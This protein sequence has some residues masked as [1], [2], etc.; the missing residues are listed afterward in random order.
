MLKVPQQDLTLRIRR[1]QDL[2]RSMDVDALVASTPTALLYLY[3]GVYSGVAY[4]PREGEAQYF[5]R[6]PSSS[7]SADDRLNYIRKI[8]QITTHIETNNIRKVALELDE[9]PYNDIVRQQ[10]IFPN[11]SLANATAILRAV[12]M[13]KTPYEIEQI[14][15]G[16]QKHMEVYRR[17]KDVYRSG[18][19]DLE[20]QIEIEHL[21][22]EG[23]STGLFRC[24]GAMMEFH[25]GSLLAGENAQI[26]SPYDFALGGAGSTALPLGANGTKLTHG[27]S[28][29]VDMAGNYGVYLSDIT[30][31]YAIGTLPDE[32]YKLHELSRRIHREVIQ[33]AKA[34]SLCSELYEKSLNIVKQEQAQSYFMGFG[35]QAQFVGHGLGL[36]INELPVL[37]A[38][39]KDRLEAGMVVAFEP[40]FVLPNVGALGVEN[41]YLIGENTVE[42]LTPLEEEIIT[43]EP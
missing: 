11:A 24:F 4:I 22:R 25:M 36:Q 35:H 6:R 13:V 41:T 7:L 19:T 15:Q 26:P 21:M 8:E 5:V 31:T 37:T 33:G 27:I 40:K 29:M 20:F 10:S 28:I 34:G 39:S 17:I 30:R 23:G 14:R 1:L 2:M 3:G 32:A 42:N 18:M 38:R 9:L 16:C 43:L 12:R